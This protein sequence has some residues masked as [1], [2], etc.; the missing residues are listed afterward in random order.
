[1]GKASMSALIKPPLPPEI[2]ARVRKLRRNATD[3]EQFM[4][5]FLRNR[6][7]NEAKFRRQHPIRGY[8]LDFYCHELKLGIEL[9]G[10]GH[11]EP[12]QMRYDAERTSLLA[13]EGIQ[14]IRLWNCDV[15]NHAE[16]VLGV[17]WE[18]IEVRRGGSS[19]ASPPLV[20]KG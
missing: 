11:L 18:A 8:I 10:S 17:I 19:S 12:E 20:G 7:M 1:M 3:T 4:W 15:L 14:V 5:F 16:E 9:D 13:E 2:L 6:A